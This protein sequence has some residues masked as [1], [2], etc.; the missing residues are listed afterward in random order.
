MYDTY[1]NNFFAIRNISRPESTSEAYDILSAQGKP[2][3]NQQIS[4]V[5]S[6]NEPNSVPPSHRVHHTDLKC[7]PIDNGS[8]QTTDKK[9]SEGSIS[10]CDRGQ[11][12]AEKSESSH[13]LTGTSETANHEQYADPPDQP[14]HLLSR[15]IPQQEPEMDASNSIAQD[16]APK[17][18]RGLYEGSDIRVCEDCDKTASVI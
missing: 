4:S 14:V 17:H 16:S 9:V 8:Q 2:M 1:L 6:C 15:H 10:L 13:E 12:N 11:G 3:E 7:L 18:I 5:I